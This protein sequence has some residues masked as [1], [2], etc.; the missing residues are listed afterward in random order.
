MDDL[1]CPDSRIFFLNTDSFK[2]AD[3]VGSEWAELDGAQFFRVQDKDAIEGYIR[4]YWQLITVQ[5][6]ANGVI[7]DVTDISTIDKVAA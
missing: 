2:M 7:E 1:D 4:K 5:R 6:N 3:L